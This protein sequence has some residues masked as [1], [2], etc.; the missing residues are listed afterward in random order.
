M[1]VSLLHCFI[2]SSVV[3]CSRRIASYC[4]HA[5]SSFKIANNKFINTIANQHKKSNRIRWNSILS[6]VCLRYR[7][8]GAFLVFNSRR[9]PNFLLVDLWGRSFRVS[10]VLYFVIVPLRN[11][12]CVVLGITFR[13]AHAPVM[14]HPLRFQRRQTDFPLFDA[15]LSLNNTLILYNTNYYFHYFHCSHSVFFFCYFAADQRCNGNWERNTRYLEEAR[16]R[17]DTSSRKRL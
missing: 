8:D 6:N 7:R 3:I 16:E 11:M 17:Q 12:L 2:V 5:G 10:F 14:A 1:A 4:L 13:Y 9:M 15:I